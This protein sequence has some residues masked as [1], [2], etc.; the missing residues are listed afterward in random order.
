M[1][2]QEIQQIAEII[3]QTV[4]A[5]RIYLFGSHAYGQPNRHSDYDFFVV[6]PDDFSR[7][8]DATRQIQ[9]AVAHTPLMTPIDVLAATVQRFD[10]MK[11]Y[12]TLE[13]KVYREGVLLYERV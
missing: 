4:P 12:N 13:R 1:V 9:R 3:K 11:K 7:S 2:N 5:E 10:E 8:R 6:L